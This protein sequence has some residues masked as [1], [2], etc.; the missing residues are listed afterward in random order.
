MI[1]LGFGD[2]TLTT[3]KKVSLGE[4]FVNAVHYSGTGWKGIARPPVCTGPM[5]D[6]ARL[7]G[8]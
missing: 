1:R 2:K 4:Q 3:I 8:T 5:L 7:L 6:V